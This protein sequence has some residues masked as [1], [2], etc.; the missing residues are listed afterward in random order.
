MAV[1]NTDFQ[2][3]NGINNGK[4]LGSKNLIE[5][6]RVT[7]LKPTVVDMPFLEKP[8]TLFPRLTEQ[9]TI[10]LQ[11]KEFFDQVLKTASKQIINKKIKIDQ[12]QISVKSD[13]E[14]E[15]ESTESEDEIITE[16]II[17][18]PIEEK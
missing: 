18:S 11:L 4:L 12:N 7:P 15:S 14:I 16:R 6:P 3:I 5:H 9:Q 8:M 13:T 10:R 17:I 1:P 2:L